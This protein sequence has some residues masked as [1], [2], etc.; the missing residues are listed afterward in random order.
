MSDAELSGLQ[1]RVRAAAAAKT[2]LAIRGGGTRDFYGQAIMWFLIA[3]APK[4]SW[5]LEAPSSAPLIAG[6]S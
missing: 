4:E 5:R 3:T 1:E 2:P 6:I